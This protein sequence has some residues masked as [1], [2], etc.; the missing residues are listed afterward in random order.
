MVARIVKSI[1][2]PF[3]E[4]M[5]EAVLAAIVS[6]TGFFTQANTTASSL[7]EAADM[8]AMGGDLEGVNT[9]LNQSFSPARMRLL[10]LSLGSME[11]FREGRVA[12]MSLTARMLAEARASLED[13][14]GFVDFPRSVK[15]VELAAFL[16][17]D[18]RGRVKVSLRSRYPVSARAVATGYGGGGHVL[19]AAYTDH[20]PTCA[21]A[22]ERFLSGLGHVLPEDMG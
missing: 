18:G 16:K 5:L 11:F 10:S 15:G 21:E 7:R 9:K 19:A 3:S 20:S 22:R 17:E 8:V 12:V 13:A 6:D 2:A 14:E 1:N 4:P